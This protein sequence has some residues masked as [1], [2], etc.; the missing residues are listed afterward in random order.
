MLVEFSLLA[1]PFLLLLLGAFDIGFYYWGSEELENATAH[2][3]RLVRT[4]QVQTGGITQAQL[5]AEICGKTRCLS[6][7]PPG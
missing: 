6:A 5:K 7:A 4:G 2:G 3:A 1:L